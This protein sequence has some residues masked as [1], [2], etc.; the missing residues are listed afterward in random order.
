[1]SGHSSHETQE[2]AGT[3]RLF[4]IVWGWLVALTLVEVY[5]AYIHLA[6]ITTLLLLIGLSVI[7]AG[8]IMAYFM[9]LKFEK[10]SLVLALVPALLICIGLLTLIFPDSFR[11]LELGAR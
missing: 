7:K 4:A 3:T 10:F 1:M 11:L 5:L 8:L 9:H 2:F 6:V